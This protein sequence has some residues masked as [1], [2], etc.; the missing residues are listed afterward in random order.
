MS[1]HHPPTPTAPWRPL[2]LA[3]A[4]AA[5]VAAAVLAVPAPAAAAPTDAELAF[6]WAPVHY[7]DTDDTDADADFVTAVDYDGDWSTIDNWEHQDDDRGRLR[8]TASYSV[9][10]TGTHWFLV[11]A[12]YHPRDWCDVVFCQ[13]VNDHHEN[14]MEGLLL[15][16]RKDGTEF[17]RLEAMVTVAHAHFYSYVPAAGGFRGGQE[18]V[19]G[20]IVTRSH[21]G[22]ANRPTTFQ[23]AKGHGLFAWGGG[24]FPGGDGVVYLPSRSVSEV[25]SS[26]NDRSVAYTLTGVFAAG[27]LWARRSNPETFAR[28]G[29][30]RG[31]N[32][33]DNAANAP[34]G[35]DDTDDGGQL[36]GGELAT[37]PAK[38]IAIYFSNLG[39]FSRAYARN[40][41]LG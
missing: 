28:F 21:D 12:F 23:E 4:L 10:E 3:L 40:G 27:G 30:F 20:T 9:V 2:A 13:V 8:A 38:L 5:F 41:Y 39:A 18:D 34:W 16:V 15:T 24:G 14:D 1:I 6:H 25:P 32:G 36:L 11:Y 19:D 31:D 37:D 29:A 33:A 26:G 35:W 17:G 22:T 7:Q